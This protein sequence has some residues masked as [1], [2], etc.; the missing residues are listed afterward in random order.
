MV[1]LLVHKVQNTAVLLRRLLPPH[2]V[3]A[4]YHV[5][6][7]IFPIQQLNV[8]VKLLIGPVIHSSA[9]EYTNNL[10]QLHHASRQLAHKLLKRDE[11]GLIQLLVEL[12]IDSVHVLLVLVGVLSSPLLQLGCVALDL[13]NVH[14]VRCTLHCQPIHLFTHLSDITLVLPTCALHPTDAELQSVHPFAGLLGNISIVPIRVLRTVCRFLRLLAHILLDVADVGIQLS[15]K[16]LLGL[17][18]GLVGAGQVV[19]SLA[20]LLVQRHMH[21][22]Q[23]VGKS[24]EGGVLILL[25]FVKGVDVPLQVFSQR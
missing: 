7:A 23:V 13:V 16:I 11:I 21:L 1:C 19:H 14:V 15:L 4:G 22:M 18:Q 12:L 9:R 2:L 8:D 25:F 17:R 3:H 5:D 10:R 24:L 6:T 20:M